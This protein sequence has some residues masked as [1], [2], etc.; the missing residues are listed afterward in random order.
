ML[1]SFVEHGLSQEE[2][3]AETMAQV[4]A[5]SDTS[6]GAIRLT[7]LYMLTNPRVMEN[8]RRIIP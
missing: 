3:E 1:G 6:A 2:A 4:I 5:G 8:I 7:L